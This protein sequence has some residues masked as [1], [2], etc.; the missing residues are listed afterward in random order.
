MTTLDARGLRALTLAMPKAELHLHLD[1]SLRIDTALELARTR[2]VEAP[3]T[4]AGMR[5]VLVGPEQV[6]DQ[7][8]LL[9]AFDLP[10]ALMQD[11][12]ALERTAADL[13]EDKARE[14]RPLRGDPVGAAAPHG[15]RPDRTAG[16]RGDVARRVAMARGTGS[17]SG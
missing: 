16:R 15:P 12:E 4:F 6:E 8:R 14:Q 1:G 5:D 17:R 2:G 3:T 11:A 10:I 9:L 7:A 13:V